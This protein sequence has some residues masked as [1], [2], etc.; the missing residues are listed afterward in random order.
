MTDQT[1]NESTT[2]NATSVVACV[3][4]E[5]LHAVIGAES[6]TTTQVCLGSAMV[7]LGVLRGSN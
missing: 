6:A 4:G 3:T 2:T 1:T 5:T 7:A